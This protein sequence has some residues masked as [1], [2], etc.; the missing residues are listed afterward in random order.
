MN[1]SSQA[2]NSCV[3]NLVMFWIFSVCLN[4]LGLSRDEV[5]VRGSIANK[6]FWKGAFFDSRG[7]NGLLNWK[8]N[9]ETGP[10]AWSAANTELT[11]MILCDD[12]VGD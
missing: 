12:E 2:V 10:L 7:F 8:Q 11:L 9:L 4:F 1:D 6:Y 5:P 3:K